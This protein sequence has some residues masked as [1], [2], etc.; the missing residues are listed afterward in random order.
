[1]EHIRKTF[2]G[3]VLSDKMDKTCVVEVTRK[4]KHPIYKKYILKRKKYK[5]HDEKNEAKIGNNVVISET[6]PISKEKRFK[7]IDILNK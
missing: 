2:T 4:V 7:I 5:V 6:R 1:M 3:K